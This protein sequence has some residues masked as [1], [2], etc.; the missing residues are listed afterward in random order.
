M[1]IGIIMLIIVVTLIVL[2]V[3]G[4]NKKIMFKIILPWS[5]EAKSYQEYLDRQEKNEY[6]K[7]S[8]PANFV[9]EQQNKEYLFDFL[10]WE[11][12]YGSYYNRG[13]VLDPLE[14][15]PENIPQVR[16]KPIDVVENLF[17]PPK[18]FLDVSLLDEKIALVKEKKEL[19][20]NNYSSVEM[21]GLIERLEN[22][23]K[24]AESREYFEGFQVTTDEKIGELLDKY[25]ELQRK[26]VELF[27]PDFPKEAINKMKS[28]TAKVK[29]V[30]GKKP[31]YYVIAE[32]DKFKK[33]YE[34][35]DPILL[36]QSPFG[37]YWYILGAWDKEMLMLS[38]L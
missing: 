7:S 26:P 20:H 18:S 36:A 6:E 16:V 15:K 1:N 13:I 9:E 27:I 29:D 38:E 10:G 5:K 12:S 14:T 22:R 35:R 31:V 19:I 21:E 24:Y 34:K 25:P 2:E 32:A 28:Y 30:T 23:K 11:S 4:L 8:V 3:S 17:C 33:A 37:F